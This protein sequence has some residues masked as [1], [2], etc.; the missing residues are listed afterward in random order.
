[1]HHYVRTSVTAQKV[2]YL[3]SCLTSVCGRRSLFV[4]ATSGWYQTASRPSVTAASMLVRSFHAMLP[5]I[6]PAYNAHDNN[7]IIAGKLIG[8]HF[9]EKNQLFSMFVPR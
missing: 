8:K 7:T 1:M 5:T 2:I 4:N 3:S 6:P 9:V